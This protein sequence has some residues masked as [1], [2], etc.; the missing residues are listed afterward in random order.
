MSR[1]DFPGKDLASTVTLG[2][3]RP[4]GTFFVQ[5]FLEEVEHELVWRGTFPGELSSAAAAIAIAAPYANL[6]VTLGAI[7]ETDRLRALGGIDGPAQIAV[8][9][10]LIPA[11]HVIRTE[12]EARA[13]GY[14]IAAIADSS[15][16][17][18]ELLIAPDTYLDGTFAAFD[19]DAREMLDVHGWNFSVGPEEQE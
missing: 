12:A 2:W 14:T 7:L 4:L 18:L 1:H 13:A 17:T 16:Y 6:P 3:D 8:R 19:R 10:F 15:H 5:V 11:G 9:P